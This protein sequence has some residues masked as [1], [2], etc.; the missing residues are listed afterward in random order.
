[1][2]DRLRRLPLRARLTLAGTLLLPLALAVV[3]GL[4]FLR[5]EG[6]LTST[7]DG[8][9]RARADTLA[10][11]VRGQGPEALNR[12]GGQA[13]LRPL[14]AFAQVTDRAG[15]V[16]STTPAVAST[17][18]LTPAQAGT[19][20]RHGLV[21]ERGRIPSLAKRSR[22]V[23]VPLPG[24]RTALVVGRSLREREAAN[25]SFGRA[26]LIGGPLALL[27]T[28]AAI[29]A[30]SAAALRPVENMRRRAAE[31]TGT[32]LSDRLP[33]PETGDEIA[34]LGHTLNAMIARLEDTLTRQRELTQN[35]SHE[36]RT[37]LTVVAAEMELALQHELNPEAREALTTAL[38][39]ARRVG[40]LADDLL[41]LAQVEEGELP[42]ALETVDLDEIVRGA[43]ARAGRNPHAAGRDI[44][45][46]SEPLLTA[47]DPIRIEQAVTNL[48]DNALTHGD[49]TIT[50]TLSR[51]EDQATIAVRDE[52][53]G[54]PEALRLT[55]FDRFTRSADR[56]R[57]GA[58]LGLA[59][60]RAIARAHGGDAA[61]T[62][63]PGGVVV[64]LPVSARAQ[65]G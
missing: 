27:L 31:I 11:M 46:A 1:M 4:V 32:E 20:A 15:R 28:A 35:A 64:T 2:R 12:P 53:P 65:A 5:F 45:V 17:P 60:V 33:V 36:L 59:I 18:L 38:E 16:L 22:L 14:A 47:A 55:A 44:V 41:T 13:L 49:G 61:I 21:A 9:L 48:I 7:I 56:P 24:R 57:R 51:L 54:F 23:A 39:E 50:V 62:D 3:F 40:R 63:G 43:A 19:A 34:R 37:P 30:A 10:A 26:L 42:L 58:G 29:Y 6:A 52:G 25:E 8:D